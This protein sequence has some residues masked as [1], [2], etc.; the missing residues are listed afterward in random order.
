[1]WRSQLLTLVGS[2]AAGLAFVYALGGNQGF[3]RPGYSVYVEPGGAWTF[4]KNTFN[5]FVPV[6]VEAN[7]QKNISD[8]QYGGHGPRAFADYLIIASYVRQF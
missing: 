5:L 6:R 3:R 1:M 8:D 7:R 2:C 4:G